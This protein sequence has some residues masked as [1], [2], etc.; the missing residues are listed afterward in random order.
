MGSTGIGGGEASLLQKANL[1]ASPTHLQGGRFC[2]PIFF[3]PLSA[4][5]FEPVQFDELRAGS[6]SGVRQKH[7]RGMVTGPII[8][9]HSRNSKSVTNSAV[10]L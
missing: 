8:G 1:P 4:G 6:K 10:L 5:S 2:L 7:V 9:R 3:D